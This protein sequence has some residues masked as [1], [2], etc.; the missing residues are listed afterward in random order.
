MFKVIKLK[1]IM[2]FVAIVLVSLLLSIGIVSVTQTKEI[3]KPIYTIVVDAGH[4]GLD[5]K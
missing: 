5:V 2:M 1:P 3:P 4:G